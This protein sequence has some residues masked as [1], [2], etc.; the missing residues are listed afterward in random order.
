[1]R[2]L[3]ED[4]L[5]RFSERVFSV[6]DIDGRRL[7]YRDVGNMMSRASQAFETSRL[8]RGDYV[9][10]ALRNSPE[11]IALYLAALTSGVRLVPL[12]S[13]YT[14]EE[15]AGVRADLPVRGA[16]VDNDNL[17]PQGGPLLPAEF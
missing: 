12:G 14:L 13:S 11:L 4:R 15:V 3:I 5:K 7:T 6:S 16:Y 9:V 2:E 17:R 10:V 1:M 8:E